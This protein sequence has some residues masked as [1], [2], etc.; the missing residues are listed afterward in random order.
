M[1]LEYRELTQLLEATIE[2]LY[3]L[4]LSGLLTVILGIPLGIMLFLTDKGQL[5]ENST[6]NRIIG[7][8]V[9]VF[10]SIPFIILIVLIMPLTRV[11]V[12][13]TIGPTAATVPLIIGATPFF[14]R[15]VETALREV[16]KGVVE[17]AIS[18]GANVFQIIWK[19]YLPEALPSILSGITVTLVAL[20]GYSAMAGVV[21]G[22]GL[23]NMAI[24]YG[25]QMYNTPV[26]LSTTFVILLLVIFIQ[27]L[28]DFLARKID[29]K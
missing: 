16:N 27:F 17:A 6:L 18:M 8:I 12:G 21:G 23:G 7:L 29:K 5:L 11:I 10:R 9:N 26:M 25:Y 24:V 28:G 22:G 4:G 19:V 3:M 2:T 14:A 15:L 20:I 1:L 13:T